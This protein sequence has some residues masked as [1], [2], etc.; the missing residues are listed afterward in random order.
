M[1]YRLLVEAIQNGDQRKTD[2]LCKELHPRLKNYLI[3]TTG[4]PPE[5]AEDAVQNMFEYLI[6]KIR[7]DEIKSPS[8]LLNYMQTGVRHNYLK[9]IRKEPLSSSEHEGDAIPVEP[10]QVWDLVDKEKREILAGC[11]VKLSE[12]YRQLV[13]YLLE[14]PNAQS[15]D[16]A[17]QFNISVR[18]AWVRKHRAIKLLNECV[19][20]KL[21]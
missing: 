12:H 7:R 16:V 9:M 13:E 2:N 14:H 11:I 15:E 8:G 10:N 5:L 17:D 1:D 3:A 19:N 21:K 6:P 18:N 4:A 20:K